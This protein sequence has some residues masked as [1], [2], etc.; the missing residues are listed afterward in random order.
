[1]VS[2]GKV[3]FFKGQPAP[4]PRTALATVDCQR[5]PGGPPASWVCRPSLPSGVGALVAQAP[6]P[7]PSVCWPV[8]PACGGCEKLF[9]GWPGSAGLCRPLL[10][11][12]SL[13]PCRPALRSWASQGPGAVRGRFHRTDTLDAM[14]SMGLPQSSRRDVGTVQCGRES[15]PR[16][17]CPIPEGVWHCCRPRFGG[18]C[19]SRKRCPAEPVQMTAAGL[20][21]V[22]TS[23]LG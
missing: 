12:G 15:R 2:K 8:P 13:I 1:M 4:C 19:P 17:C 7:A 11:P 6:P 22:S 9:G 23:P 20:C 5:G 3:V 21:V 18:A 14:F 16:L 10:A